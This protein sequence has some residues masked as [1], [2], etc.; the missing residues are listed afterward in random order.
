M[1]LNHTDYGIITAMAIEME[2]LLPW[3]SGIER[4]EHNNFIFIKGNIDSKRI[5][6]CSSDM[7][8]TNAAIAT[9]QLIHYFNPTTMIFCGIAGAVSPS[10]KVGDVVVGEIIVPLDTQPLHDFNKVNRCM[11]GVVPESKFISDKQLLKIFS[12][13][14]LPVH[15]GTIAT[16]DYFPYP[17]NMPSSFEGSPILSIDMESSAFGQCCQKMNKPFIVIRAISNI[18]TKDISFSRISSEDISSASQKAAEVT[19]ALIKCEATCTAV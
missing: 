12:N 5:V 16:S 4:I 17:T 3:L 9:M 19:A 7:G 10:L 11:H 18:I 2:A 6:L 8:Q 1:K 15:L 13:I 14:D